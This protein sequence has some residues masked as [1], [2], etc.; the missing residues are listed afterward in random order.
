MEHETYERS[1]G[2]W[3]GAALAA[4]V[5][6][7]AGWQ[8]RRANAARHQA[9]LARV[10]AEVE[11]FA[12]EVAAMPGVAGVPVLAP[13]ESRELTP[14][15]LG[16]MALQTVRLALAEGDLEEARKRLRDLHTV[17]LMAGSI[18]K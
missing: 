17:R 14:R 15:E 8:W 10:H 7:I 2:I 18:G 11:V 5:V 4:L 16:E 1:S 6:G 13:G 3:I 9:E 12:A